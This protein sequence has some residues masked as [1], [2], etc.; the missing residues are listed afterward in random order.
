MTNV[1]SLWPPTPTIDWLQCIIIHFSH[2][3]SSVTFIFFSFFLLGVSRFGHCRHGGV[4][5]FFFF[6][7]FLSF[8]TSFFVFQFFLLCRL[9][10]TFLFLLFISLHGSRKNHQL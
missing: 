9:W 10:D 5:F 6:L 8:S 2:F 7:Y 1:T 4:E 3:K